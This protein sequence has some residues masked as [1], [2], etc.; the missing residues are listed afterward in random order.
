[1]PDQNVRRRRFRCLKQRMQIG[2][3]ARERGWRGGRIAPPQT[4]A[5]VADH[6]RER[7][8][9]VLNRAPAQAG[10]RQTGLEYDG[11]AALA[12]LVGMQSPSAEIE[13][14]ARRRI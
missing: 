10:R 7:G 2:G 11:G 14:T 13:Q 8:D 9:L 3:E 1:M 12:E 4:G 6:A 5:I